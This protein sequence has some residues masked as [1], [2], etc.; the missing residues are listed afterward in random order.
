[1]K[2]RVN[3]AM[4]MIF[5]I[6]PFSFLSCASTQQTMN[7]EAQFNV[8]EGIYHIKRG[9]YDQAILSSNKALEINPR[10]DLAFNVRG[11]AYWKKGQYDQAISEYNKA[12]KIN[13]RRGVH[14]VSRGVAYGEKKEFDQAISNF[15]KALEINPRGGDVYYNRAVSYSSKREY[16]KSWEDVKMAQKLGY[17]VPLQFLDELGKAS[18][19]QN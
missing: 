2:N 11:I 17:Q 19:R 8:D 14:Y 12:I 4:W 16:D 10:N 1:M 9:E 5:L 13:P 15:N 7:M 3:I 6:I 18:G